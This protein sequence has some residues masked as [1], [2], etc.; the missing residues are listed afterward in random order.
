MSTRTCW[1][2][3]HSVCAGVG[4]AVVTS[5]AASSGDEALAVEGAGAVGKNCPGP[6]PVTCKF[7]FLFLSTGY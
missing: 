7:P 3:F 6:G 5:A 2:I 4:I 1:Q